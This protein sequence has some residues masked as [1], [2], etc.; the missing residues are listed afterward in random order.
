MS[1]FIVI[2][3]L[4]DTQSHPDV[5]QKFKTELSILFRNVSVSFEGVELQ[6]ST[7]AK[8]DIRFKEN[9]IDL[10][11]ST[12]LL[13]V[14]KD[15]V[16]PENIASY[17]FSIIE[18]LNIVIGKL[19]INAIVTSDAFKYQPFIY[20]LTKHQSLDNTIAGVAYA[21]GSTVNPAW[22]SPLTLNKDDIKNRFTKAMFGSGI[23]ENP[24]FGK[25]F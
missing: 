10:P 19:Y 15:Y 22:I 16:T 24:P 8:F 4:T 17:I 9:G 5:N 25:G 2:Y 13:E 6:Q 18:R 7:G 14:D 11:N 12:F 1:T 3:D 20:D 21:T 23:K